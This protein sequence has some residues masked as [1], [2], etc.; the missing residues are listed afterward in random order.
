RPRPRGGARK[1]AGLEEVRALLA[2]DAPGRRGPRA[3]HAGRALRAGGSK[4]P[5]DAVDLGPGRRDPRRRP[6]HE[7]VGAARASVRRGGAGGPWLLLFP[8]RHASRP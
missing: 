4:P 2:L 6:D 5:V 3:T 8:P 1:G 7:V